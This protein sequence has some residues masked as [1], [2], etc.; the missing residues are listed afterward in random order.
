MLSVMNLEYKPDK[1]RES[2]C[3][4]EEITHPPEPLEVRYVYE[5]PKNTPPPYENIPHT[6]YTVLVIGEVYVFITSA[7]SVLWNIA[8]FSF[9]DVFLPETLL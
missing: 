7:I 5:G 3:G 4:L 2:M 9:S 8:S 6:S 1:I